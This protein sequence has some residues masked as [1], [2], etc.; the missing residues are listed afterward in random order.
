MSGTIHDDHPFLD[1][2]GD[3]HPVRRLRGRLGAPVT[4][5]TAGSRDDRVGLTISSLVVVEGEPPRLHFLL[6]DESRLWDRIRD[7]G[8]FVVHVLEY[9]HR[10][11]AGRF[12]GSVPSPGGPFAGLE[13]IDGECGPEL[14][15]VP[16]RARCRF[17]GGRPG[18]GGHVVVDG[19][20]DV[21]ELSDLEDPL[22]WFRGRYR[23]LQP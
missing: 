23:R 19:V 6:G 16:T 20:I 9:R 12:A 18:D 11:L 14:A 4:V 7:H 8:S 13:V 10:P 3:R 22:V 21:V 17:D 15:D 1:P 2:E 5:V